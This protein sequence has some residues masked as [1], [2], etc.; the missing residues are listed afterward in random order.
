MSHVA[1][2]IGVVLTM[3]AVVGAYSYGDTLS[4]LSWVQVHTPQG[5]A[6]GGVLYLCWDTAIADQGEKS[7]A[8]QGEKTN[9]K[10]GGV[11]V[12]PKHTH[13]YRPGSL[14]QFGEPA[15]TKLE[16]KVVES[17][18]GYWGAPSKFSVGNWDCSTWQDFKCGTT[19]CKAC[20][21]A[22]LGLTF[23]AFIGLLSYIAFY[24]HCDERLL[25]KDSNFV[26]FVTVASAI[27]G[28]SNFLCSVFGYWNSCVIIA[29]SL[30]D[31]VVRAG[32]GLWCITAAAVL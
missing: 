6:H 27:I 18:M 29:K 8:G 1:S 26:K 3:L 31:S 14:V 17:E 4:Y 22:S 32:W 24:K 7:N 19:P 11:T 30:E 12:D 21:Y 9:A 16:D 25:G 20:K 2:A 28:G 10:M 13:G 23:S 5:E 15:G